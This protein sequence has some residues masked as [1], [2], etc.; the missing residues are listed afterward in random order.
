D[1]ARAIAALGLYRA[2]LGDK[3][4]ALALVHRAERLQVHEAEVAMFNAE[5]FARLGDIKAARERIARARQLGVPES[6]ISSNAVFRRLG[7]LDSK[8][9]EQ[10]SQ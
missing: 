3:E 5:T 10:Q 4:L 2:I 9:G 7:L 1:D 6:A 8:G